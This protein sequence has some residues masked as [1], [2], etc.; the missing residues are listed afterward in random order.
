MMALFGWLFGTKPQPRQYS[1]PP[2]PQPPSNAPTKA[3]QARPAKKSA[4]L[5]EIRD[6]GSDMLATAAMSE[7]S[8]SPMPIISSSHPRPREGRFSICWCIR[9]KTVWRSFANSSCQPAP[10]ALNHASISGSIAS[11]SSGSAA[12]LKDAAIHSYLSIK[13]TISRKYLYHGLLKL[14]KFVHPH[15]DTFGPPGDCSL[16][17]YKATEN[18]SAGGSIPPLGTI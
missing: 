11:F 4:S 8:P 6:L 10:R 18:R 16:K 9:R 5:P 7:T 12:C 2:K 1:G 17:T 15:V 3:P 14:A 13:C